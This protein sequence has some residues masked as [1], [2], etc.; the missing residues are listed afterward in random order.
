MVREVVLISRSIYVTA[1]SVRATWESPYHGRRELDLDREDLAGLAWEVGS[2]SLSARTCHY[3][4]QHSLLKSALNSSPRWAAGSWE[5]RC[6]IYK[7]YPTYIP[8]ISH[9]YPTSIG[10][11]VQVAGVVAQEMLRCKA[12]IMRCT[13]DHSVCHATRSAYRGGRRGAAPKR[14]HLPRGA[15]RV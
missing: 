8:P 11:R 4:H 13:S 15:P 10:A 2:P 9:L 1:F 12:N 6:L 5:R 14:R 7:L 3:H